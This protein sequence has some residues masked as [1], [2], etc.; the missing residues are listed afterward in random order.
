MKKSVRHYLNHIRVTRR[1]SNHTVRAYSTDLD[2][3][4]RFLASQGIESF[5]HVNPGH[6]ERFLT[7]SE[8]RGLRASS[9]A[10]RISAVR[11]LHHYCAMNGV[12]S[13]NPGLAVR[14]PRRLLRL[15]TVL[16]EAQVAALIEG[17]GGSREG[18]RLRA[19]IE[20][21]YSVALRLAEL[22]G[23]SRADLD[24]G[25]SLV[26]IMGKGGREA[27]MPFGESAGAALG[28]YLAAWPDIRPDGPLFVGPSG[29]RLSDR[30]AREQLANL[31][32]RVLPGV[33]VHPH[34]LRH[35]AATHM[36]ARG[37]D[38]LTLKELLRH[39]QIETTL[40]YTH[41]DRTRMRDVLKRFHP[42]G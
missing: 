30:Q 13:T 10:R 22:L 35:S 38:I 6:L 42:R 37:A 40:I 12:A 5:E 33:R 21:A 16:T 36:H 7:D 26:R 14:S 2:A 41:F 11:G 20:L 3:Y 27:L 8:A 24:L 15:P 28:R 34:A 4:L 23:I 18:L 17:C 29:R 31:G 39:R 1:M 9:R 25:A 32:A 19:M